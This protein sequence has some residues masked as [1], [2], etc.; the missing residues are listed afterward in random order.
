MGVEPSVNK[1]MFSSL[2]VLS[3][4]F[5]SSCSSNEGGNAQGA[6]NYNQI[7]T[8]VKDIMQTE[9]GQKAIQGSL[10]ND[11]I[12]NA[13]L[14]DGEQVKSHIENTLLSERGVNTFQK[15][16][17]DPKFSSKLAKALQKENEKVQKDLM[18]DPEYQKMLIEVMKDP[19]FEKNMLQLMKSSAY[20]QQMMTVIK[21]SLQSPLFQEDLLKLITKVQE[22]ASKPKKKEGEGSKKDSGGQD[23]GG[24]GGQ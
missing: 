13:L 16:I 18:K 11:E 17:D 24:G 8:M 3:L 1:V 19:E 14:F 10:K 20:R 2:M 21:E 9:D 22:E 23:G 5:L 15:M 12:K 6:P 7:K 4:L